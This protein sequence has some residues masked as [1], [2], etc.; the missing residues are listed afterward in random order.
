MMSSETWNAGSD[1]AERAPLD[2]AARLLEAPAARAP[3]ISLAMA[4]YGPFMGPGQGGGG[5]GLARGGYAAGIADSGSA[6]AEGLA[7]RAVI[8]TTATTKAI[9]PAANTVSPTARSQ[10]SFS[11]SGVCRNSGLRAYQ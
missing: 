1:V 5:S 6:F 11:M 7:R 8:W 2:S 10:R 9:A 3:N 4:F